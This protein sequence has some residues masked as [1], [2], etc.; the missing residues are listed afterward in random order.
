MDIAKVLKVIE[1][2]KTRMPFL[3]QYSEFIEE[4]LPDRIQ[5][6]DSDEQDKKED[7]EDADEKKPAVGAAESDESTKRRYK[8]GIKITLS[9]LDFEV[10]SKVGYQKP[11]PRVFIQPVSRPQTAPA[12]PVEHHGTF[13]SSAVDKTRPTAWRNKKGNKKQDEEE[14]KTSDSRRKKSAET[15]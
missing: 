5:K 4:A 9:R 15:R 13:K 1:I 2:V 12:A 6:I 7:E 10:P 14:Q 11:K 8:A 3:H